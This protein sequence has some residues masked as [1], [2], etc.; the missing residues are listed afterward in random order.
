M[1]AQPGQFCKFVP[2]LRMEQRSGQIPAS[3]A[4]KRAVPDQ[5][6]GS[7][8]QRETELPKGKERW[9]QSTVSL[10]EIRRESLWDVG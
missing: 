8:L 9:C 4:S 2:R 5:G 1:T 10:W 6:Q 3:L 7:P